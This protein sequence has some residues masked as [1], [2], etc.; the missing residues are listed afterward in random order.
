MEPE[1][2]EDEEEAPSKKKNVV[3]GGL[4]GF[5]V[6]KDLLELEFSDP[7]IAPPEYRAVAYNAA[8]P[9]RLR[10][11][12]SGEHPAAH[13]CSTWRGQH[14]TTF[15]RGFCDSLKLVYHSAVISAAQPAMITS[16]C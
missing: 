13:S 2:E 11:G 16:A 15:L 12:L 5:G 14:C 1:P 3:S 8:P 6:A 9:V 7:E 4:V 10:S